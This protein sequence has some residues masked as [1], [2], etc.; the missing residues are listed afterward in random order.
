VGR[1]YDFRL[2]LDLTGSKFENLA[3]LPF[4]GVLGVS[5]GG[6]SSKIGI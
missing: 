3:K 2:N 6:N 1:G 5:W 4:N